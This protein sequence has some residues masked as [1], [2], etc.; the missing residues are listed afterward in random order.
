MQPACRRERQRWVNASLSGSALR[1]RPEAVTVTSRGLDDSW[2]PRVGLQLPAQPL[3]E[4]PEVVAV[5][6]VF[7]T[8]H[9]GE[10]RAMVEGSARMLCEECEKCPL[11]GRQANLDPRTRDGPRAEVYDDLIDADHPWR[12]ARRVDA[13][14]HGAHA[15]EKLVCPEWFRK[16]VV[17]AHI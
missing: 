7:K 8:P 2:V 12:R 17:G 10:K 5:P 14:E 3:D 13:T 4:S 1:D 6:N 15:C 11:R 9:S 16:V